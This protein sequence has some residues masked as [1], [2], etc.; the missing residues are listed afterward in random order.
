[1]PGPTRTWPTSTRIRVRARNVLRR[2]ADAV[3]DQRLQWIDPLAP[4]TNFRALI[5]A[6]AW[7]YA[8][9]HTTDEGAVLTE[10]DLDEI[11]RRLIDAILTPLRKTENVREV[12]PA[13]T[14]P[15]TAALLYLALRPGFKYRTRVLDWQPRIQALLDLD[16]LDATDITAHYVGEVLWLEITPDDITGELLWAVDYIDDEEW[17]R[18]TCDDLQLGSVELE[19]PGSGQQLDARLRVAGIDDPLSDPTTLRLLSRLNGYRT[20]SS[21]AIFDSAG[22]WRLAIAPGET[23][24]LKATWLDEGYVESRES[25]SRRR[26]HKLIGSGGSLAD[27]F[28]PQHRAAS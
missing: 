14:L 22:R 27:L 2:W 16:L 19:L 21:V 18:R 23:V 28:A 17:C 7:L 8:V 24:A 3:G 15:L 6:L 12:L 4:L 20:T 11:F 9:H 10:D 5:D 26:L 1:V 25:L 13:H